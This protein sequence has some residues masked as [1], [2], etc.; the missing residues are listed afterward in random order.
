[1]TPRARCSSHR[2]PPSN[3]I[4]CLW[5][6][7]SILINQIGWVGHDKVGW[8]S[9]AQIETKKLDC[10]KRNNKSRVIFHIDVGTRWPWGSLYQPSMTPFNQIDC[11]WGQ[12]SIPINQIEWVGHDKVGWSWTTRIETKKLDVNCR[13]LWA[14]TPSTNGPLDKTLWKNLKPANMVLSYLLLET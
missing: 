3:L 9:S 1:M 14:P 6:Q 10:S 2:W 4:D 5:G 11:L 7:S 13:R 8:S 12:Y